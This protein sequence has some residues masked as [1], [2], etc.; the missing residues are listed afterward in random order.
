VRFLLFLF[1]VF[2]IRQEWIES[3]IQNGGNT[4]KQ[5]ASDS[6]RNSEQVMMKNHGI[7]RES[8]SHN[9]TVGVNVIVLLFFLHT[10][11]TP[12]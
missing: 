7:V 5:L 10:C 12:V 8:K 6:Y 11:F 9:H 1:S 3:T 2:W 4:Y